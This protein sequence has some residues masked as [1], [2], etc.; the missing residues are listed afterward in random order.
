MSFSQERY[1]IYN[2]YDIK[3]EIC[4]DV[5]QYQHLKTDGSPDLCYGSKR[6]IGTRESTK[7]ECL[8]ERD[9]IIATYNI[10][11]ARI[12]DAASLSK[13]KTA[14]RNLTMFVCA[15]NTGLRGGDAGLHLSEVCCP[16]GRGKR[17]RANP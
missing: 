5:I 10:F 15:I 17:S 12:D 6:K 4:D 16:Q 14:R 1:S 8:Y 9:E 7:M 11:K 3:E 13:E 2:R